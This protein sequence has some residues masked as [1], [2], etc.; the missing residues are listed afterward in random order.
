MKNRITVSHVNSNFMFPAS[1]NN[2]SKSIRIESAFSFMA[3]FGL[4]ECIWLIRVRVIGGIRARVLKVIR[5]MRASSKCYC[6]ID[7]DNPTA[8]TTL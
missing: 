4:P 5:V 8:L 1:F 3:L 6:N 2:H 7:P